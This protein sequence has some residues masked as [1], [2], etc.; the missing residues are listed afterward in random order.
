MIITAKIKYINAYQW[1]GSKFY[2][3]ILTKTRRGKP[4]YIEVMLAGRMVEKFDANREL[5]Q[6]GVRV[7]IQFRVSSKEM[8]WDN[9]MTGQ[10]DWRTTLV[11]EN[12]RIYQSGKERRKPIVTTH[13]EIVKYVKG[14]DDDD[15][16]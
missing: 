15:A 14:F 6:E 11:A 16:N 10:K 2:Q 13:G 9:K 4:Y 7:D 1:K 5:Y 12:I 8:K 3:L